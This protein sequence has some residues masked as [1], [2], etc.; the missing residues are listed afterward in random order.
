ML[1]PLALAGRASRGGVN[2]RTSVTIIGFAVAAAYLAKAIYRGLAFSQGDFYFTMPGEY[3]ARLNA[4]LWNSPDIQA[5]L[6]FNNGAYLYGPTQYLTLFPVVFLDSYRAIASVLLVVYP[7]VLVAACWM[8]WKLVTAG[9]ARPSWLLGA[10]FALMFAFLPVTQALIQREFEVV[11]FLAL[12]AACLLL[13]RGQEAWS[14]AAVAYLTWFK[15]WPVVFLAS[16]VVHRRFKGLA[17]FGAATAALF[18]SAQLAFGLQH[19]GPGKTADIVRGLVRPLGSGK[20]L[21]PVIKRGALKSDF[22][23][24][25]V[26]GRGT[27]SDVRW[28]LCSVED[29]WPLVS[30]KTIFYALVFGTATLF[31]WAA[32]VLHRRQED[33]IVAKW[34]AI[35]EF[36]ILAIGGAAFVHAHY[37]Y[38]IVFLLPLAALLHSFTTRPQAWRKTKVAAWCAT[39]LLLNAFTLPMSWLSAIL[40]RDAWVWYLDS[41]LCVAGI[42]LLLSLVLWEFT[43]L[44]RRAPRAV[45]TV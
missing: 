30:A 44:T 41:G 37:Y 5:A 1:S 34:S 43:Q 27:A 39:Y 6:Q 45:V 25:W 36:S 40:R 35:W 23:R 15:Y 22:C 10:I 8:L 4:T 32:M 20:V 18:L 11:T 21:Y 38:F 29:R 19:F 7:V 14:G 17:A 16:F 33:A 24:Q 12:V 3:A 2:R 9:E 28:A 31:A 42:V 26:G 13:V